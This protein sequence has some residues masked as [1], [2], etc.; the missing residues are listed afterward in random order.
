MK[1]GYRLWFFIL[2]PGA[3]LT[4]CGSGDRSM[5]AAAPQPVESIQ[6]KVVTAEPNVQKVTF[7][8]ESLDKDMRFNIYLPKGYRTDH[9]YPVLYLL[10]G[11]T[12]NEDQWVPELGADKVA[13]QLLYEGK[14]E[15]L[16]IVSPQ[17]DNSYG[18]NS[19]MGKY[20]D[21]IVNDLVQYVDSHF[22]SV[23]ERVGRYIGGVSM[24]GWAALYNAFQ[25]P[26]LYSK[27]GGHSPAVV[28][29]DWS[30]TSGLKG[31]LYP[32]DEVRRQ[33]DPLLLAETQNLQGLSVYLDC[34][35]ED[36]YKFYQGAEALYNKLQNKNVKSEYHHA[37]GGHDAE[38]WT[39][40]LADYL[41]FYA[42]K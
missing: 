16:M 25:H 26:D 22:N 19:Y 18:F 11:Y 30:T 8:S 12:E 15:P 36:S 9:K 27:V 40:H 34:G 20:G 2:L 32:T 3:I 38:Y 42:G 33:R 35:D 41:L 14:I 29:D 1:F 21:Y 13:D 4:G 6:A 23:A 28:D 5:S 37:P 7:H 17:I 24:G 10:H 39:K 31:F